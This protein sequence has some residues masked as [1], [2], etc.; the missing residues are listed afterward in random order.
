M[1]TNLDNFKKLFFAVLKDLPEEFLR[2]MSLEGNYFVG[3]FVRDLFL[4]KNKED[5]YDIDIAV[6]DISS[7]IGSFKRHFKLTVVELDRD[8]GVYRV[9]LKG[10]RNYLD[11][12][13]LQGDIIEDIKRRDFTI[14]AIAVKYNGKDIQIIDPLNG[15]GDIENG[16]IRTPSRKNLVDDPLRL[17]RAYRFGSQLGFKIEPSTEKF[18]SELS[19]LLSSVSRERVKKELFKILDNNKAEMI[20]RDMYGSSLLK[21]LFPFTESFKGFYGGKLHKYDLLEHS[22]QTLRMIEDFEKNGFPID[23]DRNILNE[24]LESEFTALSALKLSA[25]LHDVGKILTKD[26]INNKITFYGHEKEGGNFLRDFFIKEKYSSKSISVIE[27]LVKFHL[28]PFHII[29]SSK[30]APRLSPRAYLK[31]KDA[32]G[33]F[34]PLIFILFMADN[35]AKD[36]DDSNFLLQSCK[37]IYRDYLVYESKE[38]SAPP[39]LNGSDV[40]K[41]LNLQSGPL[42][43]NILSDLKEKELS[44]IFHNK[45]EAEHY[46]RATYGQKV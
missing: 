10:I 16:V 35:L 28:Y 5:I 20:F 7:T 4:N 29:Q 44:G 34:A 8:F 23:F 19:F 21:G 25:F 30:E 15:I 39:L 43:G 18:I 13:L 36:L 9:F 33:I 27:E 37:K 32:L 46:L 2:V 24:Q 45:E 11:V 22:F 26:I 31:L 41:I 6:K 38:K 40:M 14:N 1:N 12:S 17:L 42:I 3:G